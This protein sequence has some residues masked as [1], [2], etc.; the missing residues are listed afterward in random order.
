M[1]SETNTKNYN[2][3]AQYLFLTAILGPVQTSNFT[4]AEPNTNSGRPK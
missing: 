2:T 4:C 1:I 3:K